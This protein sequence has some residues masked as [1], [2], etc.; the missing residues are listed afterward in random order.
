MEPG[1]TRGGNMRHTAR[2]GLTIVC[3]VMIPGLA[4][5]LTWLMAPALCATCG[6][7]APVVE[8]VLFLLLAGFVGLA[9]LAV[10]NAVL[11]LKHGKYSMDDIQCFLWKHHTV[12][13]D[14][15]QRFLKPFFP[16][17]LTGVYYRLLGL[18]MGRDAVVA[19]YAIIVDPLL[20]TMGDHSVIGENACVTAHAIVNEKI[21]I[22]PVVIGDGATIGI[23]AVVMPGAR[24]GE[25]AI[26]AP[27]AVVSPGTKIPSY[28][29]WGGMPARKIKSIAGVPATERQEEFPEPATDVVLSAA[30]YDG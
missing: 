20:T 10:L 8:V 9:Y 28:E 26:V 5:F 12:I 16:L 11:P 3:I 15:C 23:G 21:I 7:L 18:K 24:I 29:M 30:G 22:E 4:V 2:D 17:V 14:M 1:Y 13:R 25:C 6:E 27:G 19:V